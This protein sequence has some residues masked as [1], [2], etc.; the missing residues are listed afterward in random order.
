M[1]GLV[2]TA[3]FT[4]TLWGA[5]WLLARRRRRAL[6]T[7]ALPG[8]LTPAER[9]RLYKRLGINPARLARQRGW[10]AQIIPFPAEARRRRSTNA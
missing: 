1:A 8:Q 5:I 9:K 10:Q 2:I 7:R 6:N 3:L 4:L